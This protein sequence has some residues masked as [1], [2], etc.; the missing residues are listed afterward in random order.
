MH[1]PTSITI[2]ESVDYIDS[3]AFYS[4]N[5]LTTVYYG[6]TASSWDNVYVNVYNA[7][8]TNATRYYYSE[9]APSTSGNYWH[10]D[11]NGLPV[12]W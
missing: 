1:R 3:Y 10:Y 7:S 9:T 5:N 8:L 12:K 11:Q 6:G 2:P 4:C